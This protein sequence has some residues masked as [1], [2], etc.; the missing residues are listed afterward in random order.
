M[1]LRLFLVTKL[2]II[3]QQ[4]RLQKSIGVWLRLEPTTYESRVEVS[5]NGSQPERTAQRTDEQCRKYNNDST[6]LQPQNEFYYTNGRYF[7]KE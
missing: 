6:Y 1:K 3:R 2:K 5:L 4:T 7:P